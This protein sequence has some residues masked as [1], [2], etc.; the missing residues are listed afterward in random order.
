MKFILVL[1]FVVL[2]TACGTTSQKTAENTQSSATTASR[3]KAKASFDICESEAFLSLSISR[4][5]FLSGKKRDAV[6]PYIGPSKFDQELASELFRRVDSG[7]IKHYATFAAEKLY[8]CAMR[9]GAQLA[10]PR[11][12]AENCFAKVDIPF[13]LFLAQENHLGKT[14]AIARV[15]KQLKDREQFPSKLIE[16]VAE[17]MYSS[18]TSEQFQRTQ[19][20]VFWNCMYL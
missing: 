7:E 17:D 16:L 14:E 15:E 4:Q 20:K 19:R 11:A 12:V 10:T 6:L 9:E 3:D 18:P 2:L 1:V 5:Y 13:F 8:S